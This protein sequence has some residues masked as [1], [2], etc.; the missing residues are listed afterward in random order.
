MITYP[1]TPPSSP[2]PRSIVFRSNSVVT[3]NQSPFTLRS[4]VQVWS[5][6]QWGIEI[7]YPPMDANQVRAFSA[8]LLALNGRQGTF[9]MGPDPITGAPRGPAGGTPALA[10]ANQGGK[11]TI[12]TQGWTPNTVG[13][14]KAG[15]FLQIGVRLHQVL[16]DANSGPEGAATLEIFP[17]LRVGMAAHEPIITSAPKGAWRLATNESAWSIDVDQMYEL[18]I[19]AVEAL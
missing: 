12:S 19:Q 5:G 13:I 6:D 9:L 7:T 11:R 4:Q 8:F 16:V 10:G 2:A 18:S 17:S 15:D 3:V 1:L 14:L